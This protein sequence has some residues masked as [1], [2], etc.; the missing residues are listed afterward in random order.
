M[1]IERRLM[2]PKEVAALLRVHTK[3]VGRWADDGKL[4]FFRTEGGHR[5]FYEDEIHALLT[6]RTVYA[7]HIPA[8][9]VDEF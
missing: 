5:R 9:R 8:P 7:Q 4:S 6:G 3:T 1:T 2:K